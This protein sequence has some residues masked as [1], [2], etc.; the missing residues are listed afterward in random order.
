MFSL[1]STTMKLKFK[2]EIIGLVKK[3]PL[4]VLF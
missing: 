1:S 3:W 4:E 2:E